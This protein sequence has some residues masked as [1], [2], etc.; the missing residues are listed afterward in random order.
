MTRHSAGARVDSDWRPARNGSGTSVYIGGHSKCAGVC[1]RIY[2]YVRFI[3]YEPLHPSPLMKCERPD[4]NEGIEMYTRGTR[5]I[6]ITARLCVT[7]R[8]S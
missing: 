3:V 6:Y 4:R 5:G 7:V 8:S 1:T 2:K